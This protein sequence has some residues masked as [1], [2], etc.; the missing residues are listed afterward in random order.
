MDLIDALRDETL[1]APAARALLA[2]APAG[3]PREAWIP[4]LR[5]ETVRA[6]ARRLIV[7]RLLEEV[8]PG[9]TLAEIGAL[10]AADAWLAPAHVRHVS[11][12]IGKLP[13]QFLA[14]D[15]VIAI[16]VCPAVPG[17]GD[18]HR[19]LV[20]LRI[21][22]QPELDEIIE[23]LRGGAGGAGEVRELGFLEADATR[24]GDAPA[25]QPAPRTPTLG[26]LVL[27]RRALCDGP[28]GM[29]TLVDVLVEMRVRLPGPA[30]FDIYLQLRGVTGSATLVI[31][32]LGPPA[33][34]EGEGERERELLTTGTLTLGAPP[35][36]P[37]PPPPALGVAIPNVTVGFE[38]PGEHRL[39]VR[40]GDEVLGEQSFE[41][42]DPGAG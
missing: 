13:V 28:T 8:R 6:V 21:A 3:V 36:A 5:D 32:V 42:T 26:A 35:D 38:R 18:R 10:V 4:L 17:D 31:D 23:G 25:P 16:D 29:H 39:R 30:M 19:L 41:V 24:P 7:R 33:A 34:D 12:V 14:E 15:R 11:V 2:R 9:A 22:G 40:C 37:G 20:Y 1:D 27:C